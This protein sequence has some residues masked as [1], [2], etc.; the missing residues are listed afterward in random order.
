MRSCRLYNWELALL[1][2]LR[3][4]VCTRGRHPPPTPFHRISA[5]GRCEDRQCDQLCGGNPQRFGQGHDLGE[6]QLTLSVLDAV[7]G[8]SAH[9]SQSGDENWPHGGTSPS[10]H[11]LANL[12]A[13]FGHGCTPAQL[14]DAD[15][16]EAL[17]PV[18]RYL[19]TTGQPVTTDRT[20]AGQPRPGTP[21]RRHPG[22]RRR[23]HHHSR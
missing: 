6:S 21:H 11:Y 3:M 17:T 14:V 20:T 12:A 22:E 10:L 5:V 4:H 15:D 8:R 2:R 23:G 7:Q 13:T 18:D 9:P 16:L 1:T 19:L